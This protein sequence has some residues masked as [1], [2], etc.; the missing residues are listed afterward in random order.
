MALKE[1]H[2]KKIAAFLEDR[3]IAAGKTRPR[4]ASSAE[5]TAGSTRPRPTAAVHVQSVRDFISRHRLILIILA[6]AYVATGFG[7]WVSHSEQMELVAIRSRL[8]AIQ[9]DQHLSEFLGPSGSARRGSM[10]PGDGRPVVRV[11]WCVPLLPGVAVVYSTAEIPP[12][13]SESG[14]KVVLWYGIGSKILD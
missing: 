8:N 9:R 1:I 12:D 2:Q 13:Y 5:G 3:G 10:P 4:D 6:L 11:K 7:A 14:A